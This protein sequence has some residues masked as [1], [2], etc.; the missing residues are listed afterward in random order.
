MLL[1]P[2]MAISAEP[3]RDLSPQGL[4]PYWFKAVRAGDMDLVE[5]LLQRGID[6]E[7]TNERG[8]SAL[9]LAAYNGQPALVSDLL[10]RGADPN[11]GDRTGNTALMGALF[12]GDEASARLLLADP[13]IDI[14]R[15]NNAGQ[16]AAMFA[17]LFGRTELLL[18]LADHG[19]DLD[20]VDAAGASVRSL[21]ARQGHDT[22]LAE[23]DKRH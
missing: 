1:G 14:D 21:A 20:A 17:A 12:R 7:V 15:K 8:F 19:A 5:T 13:R 22:L 2:S 3:A 10:K 18:E 16:T 23:L 11:R 4:A 6:I 9:I